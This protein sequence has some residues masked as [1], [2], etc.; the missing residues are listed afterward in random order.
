MR[1]LVPFALVLSLAL[2]LAG[3]SS[4]TN[5][6][7]GF[8]I[9]RPS[10][11][12]IEIACFHKGEHRYVDVKRPAGCEISGYL[13]YK[14]SEG[15]TFSVNPITGDGRSEWGRYSSQGSLGVNTRTGARV[16]V[17][18]MRRIRC[19]DGRTFYSRA[20]I[21]NPGTGHFFYLRLPICDDPTPRAS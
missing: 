19:G 4:A 12:Q 7:H 17:T 6:R 5:Y 13:G 20:V 9:E 11:R 16:R 2:V 14:P 10:I 3:S 8:P 18:V 15:E 21:L 1:R